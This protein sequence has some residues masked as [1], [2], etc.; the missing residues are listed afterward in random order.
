MAPS[1]F[2]VGKPDVGTGTAFLIS[3]KNRLLATNA[4]VADIFNKGTGEI[5]PIKMALRTSSK[6]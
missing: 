4:H 2:L 1:V 3:K 5:W 6:S